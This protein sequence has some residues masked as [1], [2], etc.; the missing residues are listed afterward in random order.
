MLVMTDSRHEPIITLA[1]VPNDPWTLDAE[2]L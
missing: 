2:N 1:Y